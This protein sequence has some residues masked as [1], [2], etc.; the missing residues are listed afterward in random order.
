MM[1]PEPL[2]EVQAWPDATDPV[3]VMALDGWVDAGLGAAG[4]MAHLLQELETSVVATFDTEALVDHRSRRPVMHLVDGVNTGLTWP[5]IELHHGVDGDGNDVLLLAGAEPDLRWRSFTDDVV[6]LA[7][8][9]GVRL[10]VGLGAYPAAVPHTRATKLASSGTSSDL[11]A[12]VGDVAGTL[13]VPAG[14][15]A[16]IEA[17]C[18]EEAIPNIG[19][20]AQVPHYAAGMAFPGACVTLLEGLERVSQVRVA[21]DSLREA[22]R[23]L[24]ERLDELVGANDEHV[25]MVRQLEAQYD[26]AAEAAGTVPSADELAAEVERYLRDLGR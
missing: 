26:Q 1:R 11:A 6:E 9:L 21:T 19:L 3:L 5:S 22:D 18:A 4:A 2:Y 8:Q 25:I 10:A 16:A 12:G 20:W 14:I 7:A 17:R 23:L 24:R 15:Q 13:D